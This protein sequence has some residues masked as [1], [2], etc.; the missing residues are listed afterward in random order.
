M[1]LSEQVPD[2]NQIQRALKAF[3]VYTGE[4]LQIKILTHPAPESS[5]MGFIVQVNTKT[6]YHWVRRYIGDSR[7]GVYQYPTRTRAIQVALRWA[8]C[9]E[10][11]WLVK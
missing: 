9:P 3:G 8:E 7:K 2:L 4:T 1:V 10:E 6:A 11:T 5:Q